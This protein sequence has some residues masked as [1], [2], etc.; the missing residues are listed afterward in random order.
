M[1]KLVALLVAYQLLRRV[2][3][4]AIVATLAALLRSGTGDTAGHGSHAVRQFQH[5]AL[6]LGRRLQH[7]LQ[8]AID[9]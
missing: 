9:P 4:I 7:S 3:T 5:A 6:P 2:V 8:K 1:I